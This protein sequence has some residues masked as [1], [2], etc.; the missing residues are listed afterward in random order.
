MWNV[1]KI[2]GVPKYEYTIVQRH[3]VKDRIKL[4]VFTARSPVIA[5]NFVVVNK[6]LIISSQIRTIAIY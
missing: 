6:C 3:F 2:R 5:S 1:R 4:S